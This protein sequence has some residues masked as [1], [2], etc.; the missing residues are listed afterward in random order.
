MKFDYIPDDKFAVRRRNSRARRSV[1]LATLCAVSIAGLMSREGTASRQKVQL[2][3]PPAVQVE[4][5]AALPDLSLGLDPSAEETAIESAVATAEDA[6]DAPDDTDWRSLTVSRGQTISTLIESQGMLKYEWIELMALGQDVKRL[7]NLQAGEKLLLRKN[8]ENKLE[9][10][11]YELDELRTLQV[12]RVEDKLEAYVVSAELE[13]QNAQAQGVITSSLFADGT[14]AGLS[15][16]LIIELANLFNYD[17][18]FAQDLHEGDRFSV[19]YE[20]LYKN[21][22][23]LRDGHILAAEFINQGKVHRAMRHVGK[24]GQVAYYSPDGQAL[25]KAF[26]RTPV[27]FV[28]IS[29]G[30]NLKR[31][32]PI[33]NVIRAH[34]GVD[35][36]APTG[37][38]IKASG[39]GRV[40]FVGNKSGYG[41]VVI[42]QH[43]NQYTTLYAHMSRFRAGLKVGSK[44]SRGQ[45]IGYVGKS[46]LATAPHLHYEFRVKGVHKN[47]VGV[48]LPRSMGLTRE[49]L[50]DWKKKNS[51]LIALLD[52][53][54]DTRVA[55]AGSAQTQRLTK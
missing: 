11:V 29:S 43:A 23:P 48:V 25:R 49:Q 16:A 7:K 53:M 5:A 6:V 36:A 38:P 2:I 42:L 46:G 41:R 45:V 47:P 54:S 19:I 22:E 4:S 9:E 33:L 55:Q 17:I 52:A 18:D 1:L 39:D 14:K 50:A 27:D 20:K 15:N 12:R 30:F 28:R 35:Y 26:M 3:D 31:K 21:G 32:H 37:T 40:H 13:R 34:K 51:D 8:A 24:N 44:I 10:L